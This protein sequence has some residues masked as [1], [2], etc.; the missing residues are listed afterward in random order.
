MPYKPG[1]RQYRSWC[2][3]A[4]LVKAEKADDR[5]GYVVEGYATTFDAPYELYRDVDGQ[6]VYERIDPH[7]LD[8]ADMTDVIFQLN[9]EGAPLARLRN[10]SLEL[11]RDEHGLMV[12]AS[13]GGSANGRELY[14]AV[15]NGLIDRMSWGFTIADDGWQW[16]E[17][18]RTSTITKVGKVYDVSAVSMP[19]DE[20][21]E[22]HARSYLDGAIEAG[23]Q[24]LSS[25]DSERRARIALALAV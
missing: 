23:R 5:A 4:V 8:G 16:D 7:A 17:A 18:T 15:S 1:E 2:G 19:A 3:P 25:R 6:P 10:S 13:L 11:E 12:R 22:I 9:H 14:E 20:D 24:E 21:T